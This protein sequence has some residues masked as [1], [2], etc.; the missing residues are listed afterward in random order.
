MQSDQ[1][2]VKLG[3]F[4]ETELFL[5]TGLKPT[6]RTVFGGPWFAAATLLR[7]RLLNETLI[8]RHLAKRHQVYHR[9]RPEYLIVEFLTTNER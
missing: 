8:W 5:W 6:D 4:N 1:L 7:F 2:F 9:T 3:L